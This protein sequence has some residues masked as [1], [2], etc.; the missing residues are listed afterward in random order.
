MMQRIYYQDP[1]SPNKTWSVT[2][3]KNGEKILREYIHGKQWNKARKVKKWWLENIGI[4]KYEKISSKSLKTQSR[5]PD[6]HDI[7][8]NVIRSGRIVANIKTIDN[9]VLLTMDGEQSEI[10]SISK[11]FLAISKKGN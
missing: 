2:T 11:T 8:E 4:E 10:E 5:N 3:T 7:D 1:H 6:G 9:K